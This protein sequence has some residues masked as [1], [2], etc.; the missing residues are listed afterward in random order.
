MRVPDAPPLVPAWWYNRPRPKPRATPMSRGASALILFVAGTAYIALGS[1]WR[2]WQRG[3]FG[4]LWFY[5]LILWAFGIGY[6]IAAVAESGRLRLWRAACVVAL[7]ALA[8]PLSSFR[9]R[10]PH[11]DAVYIGFVRIPIWT[12]PL[13]PCRN[14]ARMLPLFWDP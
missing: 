7:L 2:P 14:P 5:G 6:A 11:E 9:N 8:V 4:G 12:H 3:E 1:P 10:C 13:G